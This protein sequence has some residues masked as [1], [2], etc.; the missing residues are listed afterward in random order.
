MNTDVLA[1]LIEAKLLLLRQLR[2]LAAQQAHVIEQGDM[3]RVMSVLAIK[4]RL[5]N[6]IEQVERQLDPFR[7][8]D[9][10]QRVWKSPTHR[11]RARESS[12]QCD[13][14]LNEIMAVEKAC[15]AQLSFRRDHTAEQIRSAHFST[16][17]A[18]AYQPSTGFSGGQFDASCE[19]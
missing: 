2:E 1:E 15:E 16:H 10:D 7:E 13:A 11:Q 17:A 18:W 14:L 9:P 19:S 12:E 3:S 6:A 8:Q 4:Q 5:L